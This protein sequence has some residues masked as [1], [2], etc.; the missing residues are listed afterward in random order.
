MS[1][2]DQRGVNAYTRAN[3]VSRNPRAIEADVIRRV[4]RGLEIARETGDRIQLVTSALDNQKLWMLL[5]SDLA[6]DGNQLPEG[7][8]AA[9]ISVGMTVIRETQNNLDK[10]LDLDFLIAINRDIIAGL[11]GVPSTGQPP[12][13]PARPT[14]PTRPR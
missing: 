14:V 10:K 5:L 4:T 3:Q 7:S 11:E 9:L 2:A 13:A 6:N 1:P 12:A 8:R